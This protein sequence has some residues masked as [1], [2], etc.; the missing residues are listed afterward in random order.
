MRI[1]SPDDF[2]VETQITWFSFSAGIRPIH[3]AFHGA[4][5]CPRNNAMART[6]RVSRGSIMSVIPEPGSCKIT[7]GLAG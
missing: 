5:V 1:F 7:I 4:I 3:S 6:V 2:I